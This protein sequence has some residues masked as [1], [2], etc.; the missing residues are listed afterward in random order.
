MS[1]K[2]KAWIEDARGAEQFPQT[3]QAWHFPLVPLHIS[4]FEMDQ[5]VWDPMFL[6]SRMYRQ[7]QNVLAIAILSVLQIADALQDADMPLLAGYAA[8]TPGFP[9]YVA[10]LQR[11]KRRAHGSLQETN[12]H[13]HLSFPLCILQYLSPHLYI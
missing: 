2:R 10:P 8:V 6:P 5:M 4:L 12:G 7:R 11:Y 1:G 13:F 9:T 3:D